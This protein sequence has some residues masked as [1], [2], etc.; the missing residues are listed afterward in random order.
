MKRVKETSHWSS[1]A[2]WALLRDTVAGPKFLGVLNLNFNAFGFLDVTFYAYD[3]NKGLVLDLT[4]QN[5]GF[6]PSFYTNFQK[7]RKKF[8]F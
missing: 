3:T 8:N 2:V 1:F 4:G 5:L 7:G 6:S